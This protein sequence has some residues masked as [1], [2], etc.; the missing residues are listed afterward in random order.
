VPQAYNY[1]LDIEVDG[2][3]WW[4]RLLLRLLGAICTDRGFAIRVWQLGRD[5][6]RGCLVSGYVR[7]SGE[8]V[9]TMDAGGETRFKVR[10]QGITP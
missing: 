4:Q 9:T 10:S 5:G 2:A 1:R 6:N 3:R 8:L 7:S